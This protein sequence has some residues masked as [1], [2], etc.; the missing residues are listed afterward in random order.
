M[1]RRGFGARA[2]KDLYTHA[3]G[4]AFAL[5]AATGIYSVPSKAGSSPTAVTVNCSKTRGFPSVR[6]ARHRGTPQVF[7]SLW[8]ASTLPH[9]LVSK[10]CDGHEDIY[11]LPGY[12]STKLLSLLLFW[13]LD[14]S[15]QH[16]A[17]AFQRK[18]LPFWGCG[19]PSMPHCAGEGWQPRHCTGKHFSSCW[20]PG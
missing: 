17:E 2:T 8:R 10:R 14:T 6:S 7:Q 15:A 13:V 9:R 4:S 1:Q 3:Q 5:P 16:T 11:V 19:S 18:N 12:P 20:V